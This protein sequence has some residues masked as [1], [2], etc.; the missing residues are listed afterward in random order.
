MT[1]VTC[2]ELADAL[3]DFVAGEASADVCEGIRGHLECCPPCVVLVETYKITIE[4]THGLPARPMP[5]SL[6]ERLNKCLCEL[7]QGQR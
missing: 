7:Q 3:L 2:R 6:C 4:V 1:P 5:A